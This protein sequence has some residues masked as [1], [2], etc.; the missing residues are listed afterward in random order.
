MKKRGNLLVSINELWA[1]THNGYFTFE[2]STILLQYKCH[3]IY[4]LN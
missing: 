1:E 2:Y 4:C 3:N